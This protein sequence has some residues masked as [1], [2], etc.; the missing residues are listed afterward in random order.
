MAQDSPVGFDS[1]LMP[2]KLPA[3]LVALLAVASLIAAGC[4]DDDPVDS[5]ATVIADEQADFPVVVD[6]ISSADGSASIGL[7]EGALPDGVALSDIVITPLS[8]AEFFGG[9][10]NAGE[11]YSFRLEP[12]GMRF[13][14]PVTFS[15]VIPLRVEE[16]GT[17]V[18]PLVLHSSADTE[19]TL[20]V[21][22]DNQRLEIDL[23]AGTV[24]VLAEIEH[25]SN[26]SVAR[27]GL[28][29]MHTA[30]PQGT[31]YP[32]GGSFEFVVT[33]TAQERTYVARTWSYSEQRYVNPRDVTIS[34]GVGTTFRV[35]GGTGVS[36][37]NLIQAFR[38]GDVLTPREAKWR[39]DS[40]RVE[41]SPRAHRDVVSRLWT[42]GRHAHSDRSVRRG[43][44]RPALTRLA[45]PD[46]RQTA[47]QEQRETAAT[48]AADGTTGGGP[49][50]GALH[51]R[52]GP[53]PFDA[54]VLS[55]LRR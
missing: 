44:P 4:S 47:A 14:R 46:A 11:F 33:I 42:R 2:V 27:N 38:Y 52:L 35:G 26:V 17:F 51:G 40:V 7:P 41:Q 25:F 22:A 30:P 45:A 13:E 31:T 24:R 6:T 50:A 39:P 20:L 55:C 3:L 8:D 23:E 1:V 54:D 5:A 32:V 19:Q 43:Q 12:D 10:E 28:F 48:A 37:P 16:D 34:V 49:T 21:V 36:R 15:A 29:V 9:D 18:M 53:R